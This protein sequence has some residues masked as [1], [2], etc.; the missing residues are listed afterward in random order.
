MSYTIYRAPGWHREPYD[1]PICTTDDRDEA[2]L[3]AGER[4]DI[5]MPGG[6]NPHNCYAEDEDGELIDAVDSFRCDECG[7][8]HAWGDDGPTG[9]IDGQIL[10]EPGAHESHL[11]TWICEDCAVDS[12]CWALAGDCD[13]ERCEGVSS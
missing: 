1:P 6:S 2:A 13:C 4:V 7:E 12:Y 5:R 8:L 11:V 9:A 3:M 10:P